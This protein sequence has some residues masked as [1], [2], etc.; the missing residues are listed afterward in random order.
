MKNLSPGRRASFYSAW[1]KVSAILTLSSLAIASAYAIP[2]TPTRGDEVLE[3]VPSRN[4]PQQQALAKARAATAG[5]LNDLRASLALA[6]RYIDAWRDEGDP[7]YLGYAQAALGPWWKMS[8]PPSEVRVL[9]ATLLQSTHHFSEALADLN[10]VV[11]DDSQNAQ[12][13]LTRATILQ[14]MGEYSQAATSCT[15]LYGRAPDLVTVTCLASVRS[16][17][18]EAE[19]SYRQLAG[20]LAAAGDDVDPAIK[21]WSLT[22]LAE[23]A[24]RRGDRAAAQ[25]H[26]TQALAL[27]NRDNYLLAAYA[28][29][30]LDAKQP[31]KVLQLLKDK[32]QIDALLLRYAIALKDLRSPQASRYADILGERFDAARIRGDSTHQREEA[33]YALTLRDDAKSALV[34][35]QQNWTVQKEP[36]DTRLILEAAAA[37]DNR[38]AARPVIGWIRQMRLEDKALSSLIARLEDAAK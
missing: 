29:F 36:A 35:A 19:S 13:W 11:K 10:A 31:E 27:G 37:S 9:R 38:T 12:A 33:R 18:G 34:V 22:L 26:F 14:V 6:R 5:N 3:R 8:N 25:Q 1:R 30:L 32:T 4:S 24:V 20:T 2:F 15:R 21:L 17:N 7:R 16:L 28:D 23:M